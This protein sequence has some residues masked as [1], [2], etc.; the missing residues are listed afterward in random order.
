MSRQL[1]STEVK[2]VDCNIRFEWLPDI[3]HIQ[4]ADMV[5]Q[6]RNTDLPAETR[7]VTRILFFF[8]SSL[9]GK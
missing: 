8:S 7:V 6:E 4:S 2:L 1:P 3:S 5:H 9:E